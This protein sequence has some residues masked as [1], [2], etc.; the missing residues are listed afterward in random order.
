MGCIC[1]KAYVPEEEPLQLNLNSDMSMMHPSHKE[2]TPTSH[3]VTSVLPKDDIPDFV[4]R[5]YGVINN[6]QYLYCIHNNYKDI[7]F[8][9]NCVYTV[10]RT[11]FYIP[12]NV[13]TIHNLLRGDKHV[14]ISHKIYYIHLTGTN[15]LLI[16][17]MPLCDVGDLWHFCFKEK[18]SKEIDIDGF[19]FTLA[20]TLRT[21]HQKGIF[22][23]DIKMENILGTTREHGIDWCFADIEYAFVDVDFIDDESDLEQVRRYRM[24]M[25]NQYKW[26][27][28]KEYLPDFT[29]PYSRSLAVRND[30]YAF[31]RCLG[32]LI[33]YQR[34]GQ[35]N[36]MFF[37]GDGGKVYDNREAVNFIMDDEY[38]RLCG[39]CVIEY[40]KY[41]NGT[42]LD[43]LIDISRPRP[44]GAF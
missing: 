37:G 28:T 3:L 42:F 14:L 40:E 43:R 21:C 25:K 34:Y 33:C 29:Y 9:S 4:I 30:V 23:M 32:T 41:A 18:R 2:R 12:N 20:T 17:W 38:I 10:E 27:K 39:D 6:N 31:A 19:V 5:F 36:T 35:A 26:I 7:F 11:K 44:D 16:Q 1:E 8:C 22:L 15:G 13:R 24:Q